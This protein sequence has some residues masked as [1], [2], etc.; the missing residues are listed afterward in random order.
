MHF[1]GEFRVPGR[2]QDVIHRFADVERMASCFPGAVLDNQEEDGSWAGGLLVT[3]GPKKI[4]FKGKVRVE[5]DLEACAGKIAGRGAADMR[6]ARV[7]VTCNYKLTSDETAGTPTT[8]CRIVSDAEL[9]GV[10]AEFARSGGQ[11]FAA[12]LM[13]EF[14]RRAQVEFSKQEIPAPEPEA[15]AASSAAVPKTDATAASASPSPG[16]AAPPPATARPTQR[17]EPAAISV[18]GLLWTVIKAK[19]LNLLAKLGLRRP[20]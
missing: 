18:Q 14:A 11:I 9:S 20:A 7:S 19:F 16:P 15:A 13:E 1:E 12:T 4:K 6:A 17:P 8:V 5:T 10:L 3:F 2:P